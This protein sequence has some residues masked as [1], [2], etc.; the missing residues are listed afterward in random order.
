MFDKPAIRRL[1]GALAVSV[2]MTGMAAQAATNEQINAAIDKGLDYLANTQAPGG[3]WPYYGA[4]EQ[5]ATGA[6][7]YAMLSQKSQ[8]DAGK[9]AFYQ[10]AVD[11]GVEYLL[12]TATKDAVSTRVDGVPIC[13]GGGSCAGV[14]WFGNGEATY[15]TGLV[16]P[17]IALYAQSNPTAVAT[18]TGPL[19][20]MSW[21]EIAQGITNEFAATQTVNTSYP[22][23]D[24]GWR[25]FPGNNDSDMSTT[26]WAV[27]SMLYNRTLGATVPAVTTALL[28]NFL[29]Y[30]QDA[31]SGAGCYQGA[32]S[33]YCDHSDTGGLLLGLGF[34]GKDASDPAV[35]SALGFLNANWAQPASSWWGNFGHPYAMWSVYKGLETIVGL[36]DTTHVTGLLDPSCSGG[37]PANAPTSG[38]CNWWQDYN[39][40][41]VANQ[42]PDGSWL[43][44]S[45]YGYWSSPLATAFDLP[46]L[47]GTQIPGPHDVPEPE[48]LGLTG[49]ALAALAAAR[50]RRKAV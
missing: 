11:R 3:Y 30:T 2:L 14:Y 40:W 35:Q 46:I 9:A 5:A 39:Q 47:G 10:A 48:T 17:A 12:A 24:G 31:V 6:A 27:V 15:T 22:W 43:D 45:G 16:A 50:R 34:L 33:G 32:A 36:N 13:P 28:P 4:Y 8:W 38:V 26:Q 25:Y 29:G 18:G 19:A 1:Q 20:S 21:R 44:Y 37:N 42:Q 41:L 23:L 49:V 7:V